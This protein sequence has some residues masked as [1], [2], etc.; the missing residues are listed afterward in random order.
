MGAVD[1]AGLAGGGGAGST[2]DVQMRSCYDYGW[3]WNKPCDPI[4]ESPWEF[5]DN[6]DNPVYAATVGVGDGVSFGATAGVRDAM[7]TADMVD[8][9]SPWYQ[10]G[11]VAG[12]IIA[13]AITDGAGEAAEGAGALE[14]G[15]AA[16]ECN[17]GACFVAGT[18]ILLASGETKPIQD[19]KPG[20]VVLSR[21]QSK[22]DSAPV[23]DAPVSRTFVHY[24]RDTE[25]V[26]FADGAKVTCTP[27]HPFYVHNR[28]FVSAGELK[29]GDEVAGSD[30][31]LDAVVSVAKHTGVA[32]VYNFEVA[33]DHT[34]FLAACT[35]G[36][37]VH[38]ACEPQQ[39]RDGR[40]GHVSEEAP[41]R[42]QPG[43]D[44]ERNL[45]SNGGRPD[46]LDVANRGGA[47]WKTAG[48]V[49]SARTF[50][51]LAKYYDATGIEDWQ[52]IPYV[53]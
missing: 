49:D 33:G 9:S 11:Q 32:T 30:G 43:L 37:W 17:G 52:V 15:E 22:N 45:P 23:E 20:D 28:G 25:T 26:T 12:T 46:A 13:G 16:A 14:D 8:T 10:G 19:V 2:T 51:Q 53:P 7:G 48:Q 34:Y 3:W 38:N 24:N 47:D 42:N 21:D 36:L 40:L 4:T 29:F 50:W 18:P 1:P 35:H 5:W 27:Q 44:I 6:P 39:L 31:T 41:Y